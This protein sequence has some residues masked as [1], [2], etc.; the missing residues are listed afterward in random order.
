M[1]KG[2]IYSAIIA[3]F[4]IGCGEKKEEP[5]VPV[6][7]EQAT[8]AAEKS[9]PAAKQEMKCGAGK[10]GAS[11]AK[12]ATKK[13]EDSA[14]EVVEKA[15]EVTT[16]AV[17]KAKEA[18]SPTVEKTK[19]LASSML[20][21]AKDA[22]SQAADKVKEAVAPSVD[23]KQIFVACSGCH[24]AKGEKKALGVSKV[25]GGWDAAKVEEALKGYKAGTYGGAMKGVMQGQA[26]KL[27]DAKIKAV[28]EYISTLK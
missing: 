23:G 11:M 16:N 18:A 21:K 20:G 1:K 14:K 25:I 6:K 22:V 4:L 17:E 24:G 3:S 8:P 12:E 13:V 28:S 26:A 27:D 19:E 9:A 7:T 5:K 10:C 15:K 2:I